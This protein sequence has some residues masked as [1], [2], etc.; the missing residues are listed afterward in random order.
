MREL[1]LWCR[2]PEHTPSF[3]DLLS[4]NKTAEKFILKLNFP[5][6]TL[7]AL[8]I[9]CARFTLTYRNAF[10]LETDA[11]SVVISL[12]QQMNG[13]EQ[14]TIGLLLLKCHRQTEVNKTM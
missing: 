5:Y 1:E 12:L 14:K 11:G 3:S 2:V 6:L 9:S 8:S 4:F 10:I 13:A 7:P